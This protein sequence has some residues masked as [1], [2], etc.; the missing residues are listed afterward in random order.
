MESEEHIYHKGELVPE[1]GTY[2]C[3]TCG[4]LWTTEETG[5]RFPPCDA[6]KSGE[7]RWV[8]VGSG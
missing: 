5:V 1:K 8:K 4:E 2:R 7:A 3:L 6:S